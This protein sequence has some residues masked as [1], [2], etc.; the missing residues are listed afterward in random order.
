MTKALP[1]A[2]PCQSALT[3]DSSYSAST[4]SSSLW[5]GG[6]TCRLIERTSSRLASEYA[7]T[8]EELVGYVSFLEGALERVRADSHRFQRE[9][10]DA[11]EHAALANHRL[12]L[13]HRHAQAFS[14]HKDQ[15]IEAARH[16][17]EQLRLTQDLLAEE[18]LRIKIHILK[19]T[20][21][22]RG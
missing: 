20:H 12:T 6:S 17:K 8:T 13:A 18:Q 21:L 19:W 4:S 11:R 5:S 10:A 15:A 2:P 7:R 1:H 3:S 16:G 22:K 9:A 14:Q